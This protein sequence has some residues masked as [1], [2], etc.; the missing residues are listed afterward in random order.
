MGNPDTNAAVIAGCR[1]V[2][3]IAKRIGQPIYRVQ[4][5]IRSRQIQHVLRVGV[6]RLFDEEAVSRIATE[7]QSVDR[8]KTR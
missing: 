1:T 3:E 8:R 2:G 4:H 5:I 6:F 7:I